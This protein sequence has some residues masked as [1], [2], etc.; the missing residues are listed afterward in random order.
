MPATEHLGVGGSITVLPNTQVPQLLE[1]NSTA[2]NDFFHQL[3][4]Y[5]QALS[6]SGGDKDQQ[7]DL[8]G[9]IKRSVLRDFATA[10]TVGRW[11]EKSWED[12][13]DDELHSRLL[14]YAD[15]VNADGAKTH[16]GSDYRQ[17][18]SV[19]TLSWGGR[20]L[21]ALETLATKVE[22]IHNISLLEWKL[23]GDPDRRD[24]IKFFLNHVV[25]LQKPPTG[26]H[27]Q[28]YLYEHMKTAVDESEDLMDF[29]M[30]MKVF[31][32][33]K[34]IDF[35]NHC[36]GFCKV[37]IPDIEANERSGDRYS[38]T[39]NNSVKSHQSSNKP[40]KHKEEGSGNASKSHHSSKASSS[41][42]VEAC[43]Q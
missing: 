38:N 15:R 3:K 5:R 33:E 10:H 32:V 13:N 25:K 14:A 7:V 22:E 8:K 12:I 37:V 35:I 36:E 29:I 2:L 30:K 6:R 20:D 21:K 27:P 28:Q 34:V 18:L 24:L 23:M 19:V 17:R 42:T 40:Y 31:A 11:P 4:I 43:Y 41:T 1:F 26:G 9:L 39:G 16:K